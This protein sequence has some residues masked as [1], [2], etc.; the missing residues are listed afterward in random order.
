[1]GKVIAVCISE[2]RGRRK[3]KWK[4]SVWWKTGGSSRMHMPENGIGR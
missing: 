2:K 3:K 1:M 4:K